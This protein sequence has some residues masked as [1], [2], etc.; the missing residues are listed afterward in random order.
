MWVV[1]VIGC[2][3]AVLMVILVFLCCKSPNIASG[4]GLGYLAKT[5]LR[6]ALDEI[7]DYRDSRNVP[8]LGDRRSN[9]GSGDSGRQIVSQGMSRKFLYNNP[10]NI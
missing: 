9:G 10:K 3:V 6:R 2:C 4:S 5:D 7:T 8:L 1:I